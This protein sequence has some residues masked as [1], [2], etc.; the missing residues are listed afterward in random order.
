MLRF[1]LRTIFVAVAIASL[2]GG[3]FYFLAHIDDPYATVLVTK[4]TSIVLT[5]QVAIDLTASALRTARLAPVR[6]WYIGRNTLRPNDSVSVHWNVR[7]GE[8]IPS[9]G[10]RLEREADGVRAF[11]YRDL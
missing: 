9:Y 1:R 7:K 5:D 3:V 2:A 4:D 10:V 8:H 6:H 11:I